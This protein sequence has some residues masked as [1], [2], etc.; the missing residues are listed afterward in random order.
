MANAKLLLVEDDK[1]QAKITKDFLES[2]G[3]EVVLAENG[4]S[5]IKA[6]KT[7]NADV[8]LL[9]LVLPDMDGNEVCRW[10]KL[11]QD[12]KGIPIIMLT[13]KS[14]TMEKVEG[15]QAGA[16]DY[17]PKPYNEIELNARI[18][19]SLR[20]KALQDELREKT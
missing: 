13:V 1:V 14:S 18:Y 11:N 2:A 12:T 20:T 8:I 15:L 5:A 17:L 10:L 6:A 9:D 7:Q 19:A 16:D 4:K 3:Y